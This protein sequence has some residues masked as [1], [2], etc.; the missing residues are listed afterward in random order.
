MTSC[1][2][3][4]AKSWPMVC[5]PGLA[6]RRGSARCGVE[7]AVRC[8]P[9]SWPTRWITGV[10]AGRVV[11]RVRCLGC[12][13]GAVGCTSRRVT[14][15]VSP[16]GCCMPGGPEQGRSALPSP[17][18]VSAAPGK[19]RRPA[20]PDDTPASCPRSE[21]RTTD[22]PHHATPETPAVPRLLPTGA[23]GWMAGPGSGRA[24]GAPDGPRSRRDA[25]ENPSSARDPG[26]L[27]VPHR[28]QDMTD[29]TE[30]AEQR[31]DG[32]RHVIWPHLSSGSA[33][34]PCTGDPSH[35]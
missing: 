28:R 15:C 22:S 20:T 19:A 5:A 25:P 21:A 6:L 3:C 24:R 27:A 23:P 10:V 8:M 12:V 18:G 31:R 16:T 11:V 33:P 34:D 14:G 32:C 26:T 29:H 9:C 35:V 4:C 1:A 2:R 7:S 30:A 17:P 13:V